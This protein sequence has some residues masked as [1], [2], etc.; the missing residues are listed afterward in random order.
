MDMCVIR[1]ESGRVCVLV[2]MCVCDVLACMCVCVCVCLCVRN[3]SYLAVFTQ[4]VGRS[5]FPIISFKALSHTIIQFS[6]VDNDHVILIWQVD[7]AAS[8]TGLLMQEGEGSAYCVLLQAWLGGWRLLFWR[9]ALPLAFPTSNS[10]ALILE[11]FHQRSPL[12][13]LPPAQI[14]ATTRLGFPRRSPVDL[15]AYIP[16]LSGSASLFGG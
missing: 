7:Y 10:S 3:M 5:T 16:A 2:C 13:T 14:C 4:D 12:R 8:H 6:L 15:H 9:I 11:A 1:C